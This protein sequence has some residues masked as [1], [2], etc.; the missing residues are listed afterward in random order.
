VVGCREFLDARLRRALE[1]NNRRLK[2]LLVEQTL[3]RVNLSDAFKKM[4]A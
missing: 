4:V 3:D 1:E 2:K